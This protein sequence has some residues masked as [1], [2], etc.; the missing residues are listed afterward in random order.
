MEFKTIPYL[1]VVDGG[2]IPIAIILHPLKSS[3]QSLS[4]FFPCLAHPMYPHMQVTK[5]NA[6]QKDL[7]RLIVIIDFSYHIKVISLYTH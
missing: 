4:G 6:I 1:S 2:A 7:L 5:K 3:L